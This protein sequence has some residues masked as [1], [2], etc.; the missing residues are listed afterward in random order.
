LV[1][2]TETDVVGPG[3]PGY[4]G[5]RTPDAA[6]LRVWEVA[7][8]A[9]ADSYLFKVSAVNSGTASYAALA[10]AYALTNEMFG[11]KLTKP[12]KNARQ[13]HYVVESAIVHLERWVAT[14]HAPPLGE[15][16]K[17]AGS[18]QPNDPV[19][20]VLDANGNAL[21]GVRSPW[22]DVQVERMSGSGNSGSPLAMLSGSAEALDAAELAK[23]YPG[24]KAEYLKRFS[25]SLDTAIKD[26]FILP[27]DKDEILGIAALSYPAPAG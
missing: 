14:G 12:Y 9:H 2:E 16:I 10:A 3:A 26:G 13:H 11:T 6:H 25:A 20:T 4:Y 8:T 24:G 18:G 7:G 1:F 21:G 23:L 15:P 17:L 5:A 27:D 19:H 22:L